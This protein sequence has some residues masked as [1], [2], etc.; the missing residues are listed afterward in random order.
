MAV[1]PASARPDLIVF[2]RVTRLAFPVVVKELR[3]ILGPNLVAY[4]A[5]VTEIRTVNDW[6]DGTHKP[7][8]DVESRLRLAL[9]L[10][11]TITEHDS[12]G[13]AKAWFQG[14]NPHLD[15]RSPA[16]LLR[17][18]DYDEIGSL[19]IGAVRAFVVGG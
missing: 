9:T 16:R 11:G 14:L 5:E 13:V 4:V 8:S 6:A 7:R 1:S 10:A 18:G 3:E 2:D 15:D 17:E 12:A 19:L